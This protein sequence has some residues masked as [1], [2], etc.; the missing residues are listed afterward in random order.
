MQLGIHRGAQ[1]FYRSASSR[2]LSFFCLI[3]NSLAAEVVLISRPHTLRIY[4][5]VT[6]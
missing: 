5:F 4:S 3:S 1:D 6:G 2:V